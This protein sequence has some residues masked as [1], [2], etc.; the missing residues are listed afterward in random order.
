[1]CFLAIWL[2]RSKLIPKL[3]VI[4]YIVGKSYDFQGLKARIL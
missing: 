2:P 4:T 1:M 3:E